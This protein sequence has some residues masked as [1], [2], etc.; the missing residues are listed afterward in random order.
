[1]TTTANTST[2]VQQ[3]LRILGTRGVPA[4]HGGFETFAEYL[5]LHLV[6][7]GWRVIVYC[8]EEGAGPVFE[9]RWQGVER[10]R[11]P[12]EGSGPRSTIAF[13]WKATAH[14]AG[15]RD[16]CLTLGY[17]TAIFCALLR[18]K[19]IPNV[20]NMDGIEWSRAKWGPVA[21]TW[22]WMNDWAG[23]WLGNHLVADHPEIKRHLSTRVNPDKITT[24]AYGADHLTHMPEEPVRA[25]GLEPGRYMTLVARPEPENSILEV[26]AGFSQRPRGMLL[27]VL[28][29]YNDANPYHRAVKAAAGPEVRFLG[30]I[31]D[32]P[33]VQALRFYCAA[34]VHGH[35]VGGTNPSL[36]EA[37]GAG[38]AVIAHDN[39]FNR[40]VAGPGARY[41][42][43]AEQFS[44]VI[45]E[46]L[47]PQSQSMCAMRDASTAR[48]LQE[49]TWPHIL[50]QYQQL[51]ER[52][53]PGRAGK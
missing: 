36:V 2:Q 44:A 46:L 38:N 39:R 23:C 11:I 48:F 1:M 25:L 5:A 33:V 51:L 4:A 32:K 50:V 9:D 43:D 37:L 29:N 42:G 52:V 26:V 34:Y 31:Y 24:I 22:F 15:H 35:Q 53:S 3:T 16:L 40:W 6:A 30:A 19:G 41:F 8:Q 12:V 47:D 28:G 20:I 49:L 7:Q 27:A 13:D 21:K 14:A 17:N 45:D 10:V 18:L